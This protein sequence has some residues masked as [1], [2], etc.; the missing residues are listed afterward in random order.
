MPRW[1]YEDF[2]IEALGK[3]IMG[4]PAAVIESDESG[5]VFGGYSMREVAMK[6]FAD[7]N[8]FWDGKSIHVDRRQSESY[9][10][11][12]AAQCFTDD[13]GTCTARILQTEQAT[14]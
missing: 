4:W 2:T 7:L 6:F 8:R 5:S 9:R 3:G 13:S 10:I 14:G 11:D 12:S 1:Q